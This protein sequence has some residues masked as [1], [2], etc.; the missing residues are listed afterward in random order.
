MT[1]T[2]SQPLTVEELQE[3]IVR[4]GQLF[5][6]IIESESAT[7]YSGEW[8]NQQEF[9]G[10]VVHLFKSQAALQVSAAE[11]KAVSMIYSIANDLANKD[12]KAVGAVSLSP[13]FANAVAI[14]SEYLKGDDFERIDW[15]ELHLP[16]LAAQPQEGKKDL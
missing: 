3:E 12:P 7:R 16:T 14:Y 13:Y 10:Q 6:V 15:R 1:E 4:L 9:I 2:S 8:E 5:M 11:N